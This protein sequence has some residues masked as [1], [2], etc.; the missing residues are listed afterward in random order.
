MNE[1]E[2]LVQDQQKNVE[3]A[4]ID[5]LAQKV[6]SIWTEVLGDKILTMQDHFLDLGGDS[7][8]AMRCASKIRKEFGIELTLQDFFLD[9][10]TIMGQAILIHQSGG[11]C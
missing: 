9:D 6:K 10:A 11:R 7:L 1:Q 3:Q 2:A 5:I 8:D 4:S